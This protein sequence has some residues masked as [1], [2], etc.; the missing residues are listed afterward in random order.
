MSDENILYFL[1]SVS[2]G[3]HK[4]TLRKAPPLK[5]KTI[6]LRY[7]YLSWNIMSFLLSSSFIVN[8]ALFI[9]KKIYILPNYAFLKFDLLGF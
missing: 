7:A 9:T 8:N 5:S 4:R 1:V 3:N 2:R 6:Q